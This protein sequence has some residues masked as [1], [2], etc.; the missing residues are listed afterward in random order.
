MKDTPQA[1]QSSPGSGEQHVHSIGGHAADGKTLRMCPISGWPIEQH[2]DWTDKTFEDGFRLSAE[3]IGG[4]IL[5][6]R[7]QGRASDAGVR[8]AFDFTD[9]LIGEHFADRPFVHILDYTR[10]GGTTLEG[11]RSFI[12]RMLQ[13]QRLIGVVFYGLSPMLRMSTKLGIRLRMIPFDVHIARDYAQAVQ[14]AR[15]LLAGASRKA[16]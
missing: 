5:H 9:A 10:L 7:N 8:R 1:L 3:I 11:R 16:H 2:P 6:T 12:K 13:R 4:C 15:R 14:I